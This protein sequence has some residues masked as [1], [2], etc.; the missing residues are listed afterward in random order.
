VDD[1]EGADQ[2]RQGLGR[3]HAERDGQED[4]DSARAAEAGDEA[5]DQAGDGADQKHDEQ[6]GVSEGCQRCHCGVKHDGRP[7]STWML[8]LLASS[9]VT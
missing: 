8:Y 6:G 5:H 2:E 4:R 9:P 1:S 3:F 7:Y